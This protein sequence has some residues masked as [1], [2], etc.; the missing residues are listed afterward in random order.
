MSQ[1]VISLQVAHSLK[2]N[3]YDGYWN[4]DTNQILLGKDRFE[5]W[6]SMTGHLEKQIEFLLKLSKVTQT[7]IN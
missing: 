5:E 3:P 7:L 2:L 1:Q 4:V 6:E